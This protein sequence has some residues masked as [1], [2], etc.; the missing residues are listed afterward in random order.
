[1]VLLL[2][3]FKGTGSFSKQ[4]EKMGIDV[5][6]LDIMKKFSPTFCCDILEWD[7]KSI[8]IPDIITASP[9]CETFSILIA[10]HK[11]Q[12]RDHQGTMLPLT[13]KGILGDKCLFKTIEIIKYFL[14]KNPNLKFSIE[15]P[16]GFMRKYF[17]LHSNFD[18]PITRS[19]A[20]Y[21]FYGFPYR[22]PTDFWTNIDGGFKFIPYSKKTEPPLTSKI[23]DIPLRDRYRIPDTLCE[24]I[25]NALIG[26]IPLVEIEEVEQPQN[27]LIGI[28]P[29]GEK[30]PTSKELDNSKDGKEATD[31]VYSV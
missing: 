8:P 16:V 2:E 10:S 7:Y 27:A 20:W 23:C 14:S 11:I 30:K 12:V 21:S 4:A 5:I 29:L 31:L 9:P 3:L 1:M 17:L 26:I 28:I 6:S 25:I 24:Y 18:L 19:T 22:K 13:E 15:N